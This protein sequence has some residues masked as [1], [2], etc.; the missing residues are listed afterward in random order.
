MCMHAVRVVLVVAAVALG[1]PMARPAQLATTPEDFRQP[2]T[3]PDPAQ[4][5]DFLAPGSC[6]ECHGGYLTTDDEPF[7]AWKT[8]IMAQSA[9]DPLMRAAAAIANADAAGSAETCIRCH[10]PVGWLGGR[11]TGGNFANLQTDDLEGVTCHMCHRLLD[12]IPRARA[13]TAAAAILAAPTA[14]PSGRCVLD[15]AMSC[16]SDAMCGGAGPCALDAG[17]GRFVVDPDDARR[18]PRELPVH[19]HTTTLSSFH[20]R[21]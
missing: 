18:G 9:R 11:S 2:G 4:L 12:P 15:P 20:T 5:N 21:S 8:S 13:P 7:D 3:Q 1:A 10:A 14:P 19:F 17:Q 6:G 16:T